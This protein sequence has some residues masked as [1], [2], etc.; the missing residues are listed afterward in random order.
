MVATFGIIILF[1]LIA[2][3]AVILGFV[4]YDQQIRAWEDRKIRNIKYWICKRLANDGIYAIIRG[5]DN[6]RAESQN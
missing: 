6:G 4:K 5:E 3:F 1:E 2:A